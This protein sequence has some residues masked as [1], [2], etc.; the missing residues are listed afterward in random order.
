MLTSLMPSRKSGLITVE[1]G[2]TL[3]LGDKTLKFIHLP[4]VHWPETMVTY[5]QGGQNPLYL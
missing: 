2:E 3:S 1:D 4:W 5:L